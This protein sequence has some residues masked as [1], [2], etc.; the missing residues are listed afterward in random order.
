MLAGEVPV[1]SARSA[2]PGPGFLEVLH[3]G[4]DGRAGRGLLRGR[5]LGG[6]S[7]RFRL[8]LRLVLLLLGRG[9]RGALKLVEGVQD[10]RVGD[11]SSCR[12]RILPAPVGSCRD[13][14][15][16][17]TQDTADRPEREALVPHL[18]DEI[19]DQRFQGQGPPAKKTVLGSARQR[20]SASYCSAGVQNPRTLR[21]RAISSCSS[22]CS[23]VVTPG[24]LP[25][26]NSA[27]RTEVAQGFPGDP[28]LVTDGRADGN[29]RSMVLAVLLDHTYR[30]GLE[31]SGLRTS[32]C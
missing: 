11:R 27:C 19:D 13:L 1:Q 22:S 18:I 2:I 15:A 9:A 14:H 10:L 8:L 4:L 32:S 17:L 20:N 29:Q 31:L 3:R 30:P 25:A 6:G 21:D 16:M 12:R 26:S 23:S 28:E 24:E 5:S 7:G